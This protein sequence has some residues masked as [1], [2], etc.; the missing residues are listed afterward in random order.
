MLAVRI[1]L[2]DRVVPVRERVA[3]ARLEA[4]REPEV[5]EVREAGPAVLA[6]NLPRTV[7]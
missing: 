7:S 5:H 3:H 4:R 2:E 1:E 6:A